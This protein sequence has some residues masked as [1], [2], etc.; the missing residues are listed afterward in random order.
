[1][2]LYTEKFSNWYSSVIG[3]QLKNQEHKNTGEQYN[4]CKVQYNH[5]SSEEEAQQLTV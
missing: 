3:T 5:M 1:M 4:V 2:D